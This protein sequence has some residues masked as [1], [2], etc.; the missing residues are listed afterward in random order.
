MITPWMIPIPVLSGTPNIYMQSMYI[1]IEIASSLTLVLEDYL[2]DLV[3][4]SRAVLGPHCAEARVVV[5][6]QHNQV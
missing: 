1:L 5:Y 2:P 6:V 4:R 3:V